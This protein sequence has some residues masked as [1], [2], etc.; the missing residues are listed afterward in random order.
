VGTSCTPA[1][2]ATSSLVQSGQVILVAV[3][4]ESSDGATACTCTPLDGITSGGTQKSMSAKTLETSALIGE[5]T[6]PVGE[7]HGTGLYLTVTKG[8]GSGTCACQVCYSK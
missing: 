7:L 6:N 5:W 2:Y 1:I 3:R 4:A 8:T